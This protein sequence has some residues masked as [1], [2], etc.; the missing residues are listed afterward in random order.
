MQSKPRK[1]SFIKKIWKKTF[2]RF[3]GFEE[4]IDITDDVA[5]LNRRNV[6]IKNII[7]ISNN[8]YSFLMLILSISTKQT[9]DWIITVISF[10]ITFLINRLLVTLINMDRKDKTKQMIAMYVA[11]FYI[12]L[13]SVLMYARLYN[14]I[15]ETV[16]YVLLYY[17]IVVISLYQDR[18]LLSS[19]FIYLFG[20][21]TAIHFIWT[22]QF[23]NQSSGLTMLEFIKRFIGTAEFGDLI[24]R[25][26]V[27]VLF[28]LAVFVIV[29]IGQY[30]QEERKKELIKRRQVQNDFGDIVGK[31]F[32]AVFVNA[33][34]SVD[35]EHVKQV[36]K[37]SEKVADIYGMNDAN[38]KNLSDY[39][40][41][42]LKYNEMNELKVLS[43]V[44]D[45]KN[46]EVLKNKT[47][48]GADIVKRIELSQSSAE[49]VRAHVE[50]NVSHEKILFIMKNQ[51]DLDSQIIMLSDIYVTL[52]SAKSYKRPYPH[53]K[54]LEL[55]EKQISPY[56]RND[57]KERFIKFADE[58]EDVYNSF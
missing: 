18:K 14:G 10:P 34:I 41:I 35:E 50:N 11:S 20:I 36:Q 45:E 42:H 9:T 2:S 58:I 43:N 52:R 23:M 16:S 21:V 13:Y 46:Y 51:S 37:I 57:L 28:Y 56:F 12:F 17:A 44:N 25:S 1:D 15:Y 31:L 39:S 53:N 22:Y 3:F 48:I 29:S 55:I 40:I 24:L 6:V 47:S 30:M 49:I 8:F 54:A 5:V 4:G 33:R 27:F 26:L 19:A 32:Q 38:I 7:F